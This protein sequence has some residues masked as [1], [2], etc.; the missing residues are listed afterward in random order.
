[1]Y[2]RLA[3]KQNTEVSYN[4]SLNDTLFPT[5]NKIREK[6]TI[7]NLRRVFC[8]FKLEANQNMDRQVI[9][10]YMTHDLSI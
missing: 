4:Y 3:L 1:M 5:T 7:R 8:S 10:V 9:Y 6:R 2:R